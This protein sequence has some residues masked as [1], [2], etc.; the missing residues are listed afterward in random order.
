MSNRL[1]PLILEKLKAFSQRR[2][3][4][5][6]LRGALAAAATLLATMMLVAFIDWLFVLPDGARWG[7]S[8]AAYLTIL[9]VEWRSCV[10]LLV[11]APG[12]RRL[13]RLV[14][15]AAPNLREDL[16]SAVE[17]GDSSGDAVYD[18]EQFRALLQANVASRMEAIDMDRLLP[19]QLVRRSVAVLAGVAAACLLAFA[20]TGFQFGTL[21]IRALL[22][23]ANLARVSK[24]QVH[25]L[26]P[27]P[28]EDRIPQGDTVPLLIEIS[29]Q[30]TNKA[31]LETFTKLGGRELLQMHP[32]SADRFSAT[33]Q[34]GREDVLYR[35]RAGDAITKKHLLEAV[36]R[37]AV[38]AFTKTY[39]F[40]AYTRLGTKQVTE[41]N[42]DLAALEGTQVELRLKTNQKT[43]QGE[44]RVEQG[45]KSY[46]VQL[47]EQ[48]GML[49]GKLPLEASGVYRV[50]L[51][52]AASG[53]ENKFSPEFELR[54]EPDLVPV[55]ELELPKQDLILPSNEIVEVEGKASDDLALARVSQLVKI[56][57]GPWKE[58]LLLQ[59]P[60]AKAK[61][62]RR[63][64][65]FEQG[66]KPGDL[67]TMKLTATDLKGNRAE[68]RPVQV[69]ITAGGFEVKRMQALE[70]QRQLH[71]ALLAFR[72]AAE[73]LDQRGR[74]TREQ[75]DR[76]PEGDPQRKETVVA[77]L[78]A[79]E[80]FDHLQ[81]DALNQL[82]ITLKNS[83]AGH[84]S[85]EIALVGLL[86][87]R[88]QSEVGAGRA[89]LGL[90]NTNP[91]APFAREQM[92]EAEASFARVRNG[93]RLAEEAERSFLAEEEIDVLNENLRI[94]ALEQQRLADLARSSG[95]DTQK[96][97]QTANRQRVIVSETRS[98]EELMG[99]A[100]EHAS[101]GGG[102]RLR[103]IQKQLNKQRVG[104]DQELTASR[105]PG[106]DLFN[107]TVNFAIA[108]KESAHQTTEL[109]RAI[110]GAPVQML[111]PVLNEAQPIFAPLEALRPETERLQHNAKLPDDA[112]T[113]LVE[114]IWTSRLGLLKTRGDVEEARIDA[115][116]YFVQDLRTATRALQGVH[117][118]EAASA[119][120]ELSAAIAPLAKDLR[121]LETAHHLGEIVNGRTALAASERWEIFNPRARTGGPTDWQ[122]FGARLKM[123]PD[124][125]SRTLVAEDLRTVRNAVR[126]TLWKA[127]SDASKQRLDQE[128]TD[129]YQQDH[130]PQS[131]AKDA[132]RL[133][134]LVNDALELLRK[135]VEDAR[136]EIAKLAPTVSQ[137]AAQLAKETEKL[138]EKTTDQAQKAPDQKREESKAGAQ[139]TLTAQKALNEKVEGLK[140]ALRADANQQ[141]IL[142][143][144]GRERA[145]DADD[146]LAML[147]EPPVRAEEDLQRA[148]D[149]EQAAARQ[150]AMQQAAAQQEKMADALQKL[151]EHY[152]NVEKGKDAEETRTALRA[153]E[154]Q[155]GVKEQLDQEFAK[156]EKMAEMAQAKPDDLLSQLEKALPRNPQM[157][158]ELSAISRST[159][160]T[161]SDQLRSASILENAVAQQVDKLASEQQAQAAA[162]AQAQPQATQTQNPPQGPQNPAASSSDN[163][164]QP[165]DQAKSN[166]PAPASAS[167]PGAPTPPAQNTAQNPSPAAPSDAQ[168]A[169]ASSQPP[170]PHPILAQGAQQQT[171]IG[172]TAKEAGSD[173]AR[174][175]RHEERLQNT[176]AGEQ[177]QQLGKQI[178]ATAQEQVPNAQKALEQAQ[179]AAQAQTA[180]NTA[181]RDLKGELGQLAT[182]AREGGT[183]GDQAATP[184][185]GSAQ[186]PQP[187]APEPNGQ[188][189]VS[190]QNAAPSAAAAQNTLPSGSAQAPNL[191]PQPAGSMAQSG[192]PSPGEQPSASQSGSPAGE[193]P[194]SSKGQTAPASGQQAGAAPNTPQVN[195]Q[196]GEE[197]K[198]TEIATAQAPVKQQVWMARTLDALDAAMHADGSNTPD[199]QGGQKSP[200][201]PSQGGSGQ[202]QG[203]PQPGDMAKAQ[204]AMSAAAQAAAASM[205][206]SRSQT[207]SETPGGPMSQGGQQAVSKGGAQ[208]QAAGMG[209]GALGEAKN[210]T[211]DWGK[212]PK[213]MAEQLSQGRQE[214]IP[215]EYRNQVE[216]YYRVI[217]EKSKKQ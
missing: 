200:S 63:W 110:A 85:S 45:K 44:L 161:A 177:L 11:Y 198:A 126:E 101:H 114:A 20:L 206:A 9:A 188:S 36:A 130:E 32:V 196:D 172:E 66:V 104:V 125:L 5:I 100:A 2:R 185:R 7:L 197:G 93:A 143:K 23:M 12:P 153:T 59:E 133:A 89:V 13:A 39:T 162:Q 160:R 142:Q 209:H 19:V 42:G 28:A 178:Q 181:N 111:T 10:R 210:Q 91:D 86:L 76:A 94:V 99:A 118:S 203:E 215:G 137:M 156:A 72:T 184:A 216:T 154:Q 171:P 79:L 81:T 38:V 138:E 18:S 167:P 132:E 165:S 80:E 134:A 88:T 147:K 40:P 119:P 164:T 217:A 176:K 21:M 150:Q 144:E 51:I 55:V 62:E 8:A 173:I 191:P 113:A 189:P 174:A 3:R 56:N 152:D 1:D 129:R 17:L 124:E 202:P 96:W 67:V 46:T 33:I 159:L 25:I 157:R 151:A 61:I 115:D 155:N 169:S 131:V 27:N 29:G 175:G 87:A 15:H 52:G 57:D 95:G 182:A 212:L 139:Q 50:H 122:W 109:K 183:P 82:F 16:L 136:K 205:R 170:P 148:Q 186:S 180:V 58:T 98:L 64:D 214:G 69:T 43:S 121:L 128:M 41:E 75:F 163:K 103:N 207:P 192:R 48:D 65:L 201:S 71:A 141:N 194:S 195:G 30:R 24:V 37:P 31:F 168:P 107:P 47:T 158:Q 208:V 6:I 116:S 140:D 145:R 193:S 166:P 77:A 179:Q 135:P 211:G 90:L 60:G 54:A 199:M 127:L 108:L 187:P 106:P 78:G 112:R 22:P 213:K 92:R 149:S 14:E 204:A 35:V 190:A 68:S 26:E 83:E 34:V 4:L 105:P 123:A 84:E 73:K 120:K 117:D 53:F 102:E 74:E 146:A 97:A 70:S 49:T